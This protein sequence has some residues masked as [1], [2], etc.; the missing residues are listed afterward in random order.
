[1]SYDADLAILDEFSNEELA[2]LV[3][4]ITDKGDW[5]EELTLSDAYKEHYPNHR[6]YVDL[7]KKEL[8]EM[9][10]NSIAN[11]FRGE[12]VSY[13]EL[14][15]DVCDKLDVPYNSSASRQ[16]IENCLLEKVLED[17]WDKLD[18]QQRQEIL[19]KAGSQTGFSAGASSGILIAAFRA[20]GF[21]SY[22]LAVMIANGICQMILG[23]GLSLAANAAITR[24]LAI[25]AGPIGIALSVLWTAIDFAGPA[26]RVTVPAAIYIAAMREV[27]EKQH[28]K[29]FSF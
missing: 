27:H 4:L 17:V 20:G 24:G 7:I 25:F 5:T 14:L 22:Q 26:Y 15:T 2:P 13:R 9:A 8:Q 1:M 21:A 29:D 11:F 16:R 10:G 3:K 23:R 18:A 28:L 6:A 19:E 12:G